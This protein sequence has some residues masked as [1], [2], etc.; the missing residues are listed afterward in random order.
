[1][2]HTHTGRVTSTRMAKTV[3]VEVVRRLRHPRYQKVIERTINIKAHCDIADVR[4][5]DMVEIVTCRPISKT[6]HYRVAR[7]IA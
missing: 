7:K 6:K 3:N 4:D 5:G 1:M 2:T